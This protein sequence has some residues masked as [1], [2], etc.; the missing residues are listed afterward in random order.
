MK[1]LGDV[2]G[3]DVAADLPLNIGVLERQGDFLVLLRQH[4]QHNPAAG[5]ICIINTLYDL[6]MVSI[7]AVSGRPIIFAAF[8][9]SLYPVGLMNQEINGSQHNVSDGGLCNQWNHFMKLP[10]HNGG[11]IAHIQKVAR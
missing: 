9:I 8:L 4:S 5:S 11:A 10:Q 1:L 7:V 2:D 3:C 6:F